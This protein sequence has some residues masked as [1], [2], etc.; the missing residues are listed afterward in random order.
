MS[1]PDPVLIVGVG[2]PQG[3][4]AA[5]WAVIEHLRNSNDARLVS[6]DGVRLHA[7]GGGERL[8]DLVDRQ[9]SLIL[10][11]ALTGEAPGSVAR[12]AWPGVQLEALHPGT[13]HGLGPAEALLLADSLG[14]LSRNVVIYAIGADSSQPGAPLSPEVQRGVAEVVSRILEELSAG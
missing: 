11:D 1:L 12:L 9:E 6:R 2:S 8:L 7:V 4:D 5:G 14:R 13:T 10:I 3:D